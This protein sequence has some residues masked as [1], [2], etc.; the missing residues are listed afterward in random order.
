MNGETFVHVEYKAARCGK[1]E[2]RFEYRANA[3][4]AAKRGFPADA[5]I[6]YLIIK[7]FHA[8]PLPE[9]VHPAL[10]PGQPVSRRQ[11]VAE[12]HDGRGEASG[13]GYR[14]RERQ[15]QH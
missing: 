8:Q 9:Q 15:H 7:L 4:H 6:D 2:P 11:T 14:Q 3:V 12:D 13:G 1:H 10:F 5:C